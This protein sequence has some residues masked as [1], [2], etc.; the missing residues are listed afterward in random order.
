MH[1]EEER[2]MTRGLQVDPSHYP[3]LQ[4]RCVLVPKWQKGQEGAPY[5]EE[6]NAVQ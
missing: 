4:K 5:Y 2:M 1:A 6:T 3:P